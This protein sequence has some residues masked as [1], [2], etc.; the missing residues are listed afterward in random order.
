MT[1]ILPN[2]RRSRMRI[3]PTMAPIREVNRLRSEVNT[4]AA[5]AIGK[6]SRAI[7]ALA[8]AHAAAVKKLSAE[9]VKSDKDL[10]KRLVEADNRLNRR[11]TKELSGG[12]VVFDKDGKRLMRARRRQRPR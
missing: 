11:I 9:Q 7:A 1:A 6:N 2:G 12:S 4:D 5:V 3:I 10:R 8:A